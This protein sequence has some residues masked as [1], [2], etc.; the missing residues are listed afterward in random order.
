[1]VLVQRIWLVIIQI[2][3]TTN[4]ANIPQNLL[5]SGEAYQRGNGRK[6]C[7]NL[8]K[9][10]VFDNEEW[11]H[12]NEIPMLV[13]GLLKPL[14]LVQGKYGRKKMK[15]NANYHNIFPSYRKKH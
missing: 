5:K 2:K 8:S 6:L 9:T 13:S 12:F 1:M 15:Q 10:S 3:T 7:I 4:E 11:C 14:I